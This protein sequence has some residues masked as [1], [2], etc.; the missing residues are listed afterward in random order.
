[1]TPG[2][3]FST[4]TST[5]GTIAR[6]SSRP[7]AC[8]MSTARLFFEWLCWKKKVLCEDVL[9]LASRGLSP[10]ARPRSP[11]GANSTL[12]TS[13]PSSA[14]IRVQVGHAT[15]R[16]HRHFS[17]HGFLA[18][19]IREK[20]YVRDGCLRAGPRGGPTR[21]SRRHLVADCE[22]G[23]LEPLFEQRKPVVAPE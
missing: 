11:C 10:E 1:M 17:A 19:L 22:A 13:A 15:A 2:A 14:N 12:M 16:Q 7:R 8:L 21:S 3:K 5:F 18:A 6:T 20:T 9:N 23:L 4:S